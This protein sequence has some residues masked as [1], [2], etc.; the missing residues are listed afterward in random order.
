[1]PAPEVAERGRG[2]GTVPELLDREAHRPED[3]RIEVEPRDEAQ[4]GD[5]H[6][7]E[8]EPDRKGGRGRQQSRHEPEQGRAS[9]HIQEEPAHRRN[10]GPGRGL[11]TLE[12]LRRLHPQPDA[13]GQKPQAGE[14]SP[15]S[16]RQAEQRGRL[17]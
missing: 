6:E 15:R 8:P 17:P 14:P 2:D 13:V 1:M 12:E 4:E 10:R 7:A 9:G 3:Q 11:L 5:A 16:R